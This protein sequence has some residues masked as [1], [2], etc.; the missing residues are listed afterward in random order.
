MTDKA[1]I[2]TSQALPYGAKEIRLGSPDFSEALAI[3]LAESGASDKAIDAAGGPGT[4]DRLHD[5][6]ARAR[7]EVQDAV[8]NSTV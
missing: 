8:V 5:T 2:Q 6:G 1:N 4:D 7:R 3:R